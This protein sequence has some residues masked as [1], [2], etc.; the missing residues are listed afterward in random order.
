MKQSF[1]AALCILLAVVYGNSL[2][3]TAATVRPYKFGFTIEEQQHRAEQRDENGIVM[4]EFGFI[5][6]DGKYHVTVYATDENGKFRIVSMKSFPYAGPPGAPSTSVATTTRAPP[7][8]PPAKHNF[9]TSACSGC[10][11]GNS[12]PAAAAPVNAASGPASAHPAQPAQ[13]HKTEIRPLSLPL[14]PA[15]V[16]DPGKLPLV[17]QKQSFKL[18]Q[19]A[20]SQFQAQANKAAQAQSAVK[21]TPAAGPSLGQQ[22]PGL[23]G[24]SLS[25][26]PG[27]FVGPVSSAAQA[28]ATTKIQVAQAVDLPSAPTQPQGPVRVT[29]TGEVQGLLLGQPLGVTQVAGHSNV[30][31]G[32]NLLLPFQQ[33]IA[34]SVDTALAESQTHKQ[35]ASSLHA[36]PQQQKTQQ[37]HIA[38]TQTVSRPGPQPLH[39]QLNPSTFPSSALANPKE[40]KKVS[41]DLANAQR[42]TP[43]ATGP[44]DLQSHAFGTAVPV[45]AASKL[46]QSS[47]VPAQGLQPAASNNLHAQTAYQPL[48]T[49]LNP[50]TFATQQPPKK[51]QKGNFDLAQ[52]Q[53]IPA[54]ASGPK[55]LQDHAFGVL[56]LGGGN[57]LSAEA[58]YQPLQTQLNPSTFAIQQPPKDVPKLN[59]NLPEFQKIPAAAS[60]PKELQDHAFGTLDVSNKLNTQAAYQ[61]LHTQLNPSTFAIQ[62]P[63]KKI[64]AVNFDLAQAQKI[65]AAA[66]GP[67]ELLEHA[68][69]TPTFG[70]KQPENLSPQK[71]SQI[72]SAISHSTQQ[73]QQKLSNTAAFQ[74]QKQN[75]KQVAKP[76]KNSVEKSMKQLVLPVTNKINKIVAQRVPSK[77]DATAATSHVVAG[78][79]AAERLNRV[80]VNSMKNV[81]LP[82]SFTIPKQVVNKLQAPLK[83]NT[84]RK[85]H[86]PHKPNTQHKPNTP[87]QAA[88]PLIATGN[89]FVA[90]HTHAT[91]EHAH[92]ASEN[93][94]FSTPPYGVVGNAAATPKQPAAGSI[95]LAQ[96]ATSAQNSPNLAATVTKTGTASTPSAK[97]PTPAVKT[98]QSG[99]GSA[100]FDKQPAL[101]STHTGSSQTGQAGEAGDL[102]RFKYL[103]DYNGHEE[104]GS[105]N[106]NKEGN[107]FAIGDDDVARTIE[108]IAN[109]LGFQPHVR[110][111][112]LDQS[113]IANLP[114][115]NSLKH[116]EFKWFNQPSE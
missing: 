87:L 67:K 85:P 12:A 23:H 54:A 8:P 57:K 18:A 6:A 64:Q 4:G 75:P 9:H 63:P 14:S 49:Q 20:V 95:G 72:S 27:L 38:P 39:I 82:V 104:T 81:A 86:T 114:T 15:S 50:S 80:V 103:L 41:I 16:A 98:T 11:L 73:P 13:H 62:Q 3:A 40:V 44:K 29:A 77:H 2:L 115:E 37:A 60:G 58:V 36:Q 24:V 33:S 28:P 101:V 56:T 1:V 96:T 113:E 46:Q 106:G 53:K 79:A 94:P 35:I 30:D 90:Q 69:G 5:T 109:E 52:A 92:A 84:Q 89:K 70:G 10:F 45:A 74:S 68:F 17:Y 42:I 22:Q 48:H 88:V 59:Y 55:E 76:L 51:V 97:Q 26:T 7:P 47:A 105:R 91:P 116:Y 32:V 21:V 102:Y 65:P 34:Q 110:W 78:F 107:Y 25:Q 99:A 83:P 108:Y 112:K 19:L 31:S 71:V 66:S 93:R 43:A 61:P 111:R 100:P